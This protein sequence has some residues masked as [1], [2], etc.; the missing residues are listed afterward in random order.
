MKR[1]LLVLAVVL[2]FGV[3]AAQT[4]ITYWQYF[5]AT[6]VDAMD[7]LIALFEAENPDVKVVHETFPY[8]GYPAQVAA[9][10]PA[11]QGPDVA[12][13]FYGWLPTWARSGYVVPLPVE[14]FDAAELD[15]NFASV[16]Q[17][18]KYDGTWYGLPTAVRSLALFYN[19]DKLA[20]AGYDAPPATWDEFIEIA[21]ALT[22]KQGALR[23]SRLRLRPT[24]QDHHL[25]REVPSVS[26]AV[27]LTPTTTSPLPTTAKLAWKP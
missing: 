13:L 27:S 18:A 24:G 26:S 20:A 21:Q 14:H 2:G 19:A 5:F 11:G 1:F 9:S 3:A 6:R 25:V 23:G 17:A 7:Q 8:D 12:Q 4:T 16:V 10:I 22:I 15:G